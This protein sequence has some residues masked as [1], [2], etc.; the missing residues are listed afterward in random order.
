MVGQAHFDLEETLFNNV[1]RRL[2]VAKNA[3]QVTHKRINIEE[4]SKVSSETSGVSAQLEDMQPLCSS[5]PTRKQ[6]DGTRD[7]FDHGND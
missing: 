1:K 5:L 6:L 4:I 7:P 3:I 2:F